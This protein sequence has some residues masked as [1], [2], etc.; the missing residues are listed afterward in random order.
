[1]VGISKSLIVDVIDSVIIG[2]IVGLMGD[3]LVKRFTL[4]AVVDLMAVGSSVG[5]IVIGFMVCTTLGVGQVG[6]IQDSS[7]S[8]NGLV[9]MD[10]FIV[11]TAVGLKL[12]CLVGVFEVSRSV[13]P[14]ASLSGAAPDCWKYIYQS[15]PNHGDDPVVSSFH[16]ETPHACAACL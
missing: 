4:G 7:M 1:M 12:G 5:C 13:S 11:G 8:T 9:F 15:H 10:C 6:K 2:F 16:G 14:L 3:F